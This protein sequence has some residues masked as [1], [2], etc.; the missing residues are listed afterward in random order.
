MRQRVK[1]TPHNNIAA[2][3]SRSSPAAAGEELPD[4]EEPASYLASERE[5]L[6]C[7]AANKRNTIQQENRGVTA[8]YCLNV[9][10]SLYVCVCKYGLPRELSPARTVL[11]KAGR[12]DGLPFTHN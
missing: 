8:A 11:F 9:S 1:L 7:A 2:C 3:Q 5:R 4:E 10:M 6:F 12:I